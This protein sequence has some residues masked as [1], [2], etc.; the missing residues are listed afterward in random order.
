MPKSAS[1]AVPP[2]VTRTLPGLT[3][4]WTTPAAWAVPSALAIMAPTPAAR[5]GRQRTVAEHVSE[6]GALDQLHDEVVVGVVAAEVVDQHRVRVGQLGGGG[7]LG[8]EPRF[9]GRVVGQLGVQQLDGDGAV[10]RAVVGPP[11]RAG[12]AGS[13]PLVQLVAVPEDARGCTGCHQPLLSSRRAR[14]RHVVGHRARAGT[15][16]GWHGNGRRRPA[17]VGRTSTARGRAGSYA[18][19]SRRIDRPTPP[20]PS[21]SHAATVRGR[22]R[23]G[24]PVPESTAAPQMPYRRLGRS[25]LK[26]S[27]LSFGSW[28]T[29]KD[30]LD[31]EQA[32]DCL[33]AAYDAGRQLLR[34]RR[35]VRRRG[36]RA[37]HGRGDRRARVGPPLATWSAR[38][39]SGG[40]TTGRTPAHTLNRKYLIEAIEGSLERFGLD[41]LDLIYCHRADPDTPI[42]ETVRAM[43]DAIDR[44]YAHY[45]GTSEWTRRRDPGR[46]RRRRAAPPPPAGRPSSRSTTSSTVAG[47]RRS[48]RAC[49]STT[50]SAPRSGRRWRAGC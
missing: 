40:C 17:R 2:D 28:V 34:Q 44:G 1:L 35:G 4:R 8:P 22:P 14:G 48:T 27:V 30:Q 13:E 23:A 6:A 41:R 12:A 46:V 39:T 49:T 36:V 7:G 45:W 33:G 32:V 9:R 50:G 43:S 38:S 21:P 18:P 19:T 20:S 3:S 24:A 25:G 16:G 37:H 29:F 31:V 11:H 15:V 10:E 47:S 26:V 5:P 42:E